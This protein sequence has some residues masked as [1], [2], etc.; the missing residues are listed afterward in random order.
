MELTGNFRYRVSFFNK[1]ILQVEYT[2]NMKDPVNCYERNGPEYK[3]WRDA[4]ANDIT[5]FTM[6]TV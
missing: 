3:V 2:T 1:V 6:R 4:T 5:H